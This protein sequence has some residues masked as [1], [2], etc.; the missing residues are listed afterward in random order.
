MIV[1]FSTRNVES[2]I[3]QTVKLFNSVV[4]GSSYTEFALFTYSTTHLKYSDKV[5]FY[6]AIKGRDGKS[7]IIKDCKIDQLGR[8][9]FLVP[10]QHA[11]TVDAFLKEWKCSYDRR[12]VWK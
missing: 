1:G 4:A 9:A 2:F 7:G 3:Y 6:Y 5:R 11:N 10:K 12:A 8:T